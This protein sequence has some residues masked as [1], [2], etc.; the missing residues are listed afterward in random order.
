VVEV[1]RD[2]ITILPDGLNKPRRFAVS[3]VLAKGDYPRDRIP[4]CRYKLS[5]VNAGDIVGIDYDRIGG[6][7]ICHAVGIRRRPGGKIPPGHYPA[8]LIDP[9]HEL[10]QALQDNEEY[11]IPLP[12]KYQM[13]GRPAAIAPPPREAKVGEA[14]GRAPGRQPWPKP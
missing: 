1:T 2:S 11:G 7:D 10:A 13:K 9:P 12:E 4:P 3:S 6:V 5:D 14:T 8:D